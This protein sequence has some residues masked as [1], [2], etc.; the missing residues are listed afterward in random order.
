MNEFIYH[1]YSKLFI[2]KIKESK[3][4]LA[5]LFILPFNFAIN[6]I[7]GYEYD[8]TPSNDLTIVEQL[9]VDADNIAITCA[10]IPINVHFPSAPFAIYI[11]REYIQPP[12][13]PHKIIREVSFEDDANQFLQKKT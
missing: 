13:P 6:H 9:N 8:I 12:S 3:A 5:S 11:K 7:K 4:Y 2:H 1:P 10:T